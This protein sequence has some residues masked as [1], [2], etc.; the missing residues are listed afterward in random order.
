MT[1]L[2][3]GAEDYLA[4]RRG[5]GFKLKRHGRFVREFTAW[6]ENHGETRITTRLALEW[7]TQPE[8]LQRAEWAARL[9]A[10]RAF[11]HYRNA[12]DGTSEIPPHGLLP[13]RTRRRTPYLYSNTEIQKLLQAA[14]SMPAQFKLHPFTYYCL[15]GLLT[16]TG[17][18][19]SE[20]LQLESR[21]IDWEEGLLT[22][23]SSKF[24]KS[25]L[26]PLHS[27]TKEVLA[28]YVARRNH[29]FPDR[30]TAVFF[31]SRTG[32]RLDAGQ[33]RR[34]F[35]CLSRQIGIRGAS[36]S[37][38]PR[39]HDF[40]HCFAVETLLRWYRAGED[41]SQRLPVLSTYLG[42]GH[43]TDTYWYLSNTPELMAAAA[44]CLEKRWEVQA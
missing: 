11:S 1:T 10:V 33:V 28:E 37:R 12:I 16:V 14:K 42:H 5:L 27:T 39:L 38:G 8:H 35:Y 9:S 25:R 20:A 6:L 44:E 26:V 18:R 7:A 22:I 34:V 32:A 30:P 40:R 13:F 15:L 3:E 41:V 31:P 43:V 21:D 17:L 29:F 36:N 2:R 23:R 24:G 19:I 4:L